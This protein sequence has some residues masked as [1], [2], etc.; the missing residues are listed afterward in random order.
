MPRRRRAGTAGSSCATGA[1]R[2]YRSAGAP[3]AQQVL[4][5]V[6]PVAWLQWLPLETIAFPGCVAA[7]RVRFALAAGA[8]LIGWDVLALGLPAATAPFD[9]ATLQQELRWRGRWL[10]RVRLDAHD[11][12]SLAAGPGLDR[13]RVV[14]TMWWAGG[15]DVP[16]A[17]A[18][19]LLE[20]ARAVMAD[21][22]SMWCAG[23]T[24]PRPGPVVVRALAQQVEP[25]HRLYVAV[26]AAWRRVAWH[27]D[28]APPRVWRL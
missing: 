1:T 2:L 14:A 27:L 15:D 24:R 25:V 16:Q 22:V 3:T 20:A 21:G 9:A 13:L 6:G 4:L 10:E 12:A 18:E 11:T 7:N 28:E 26:R 23:A 17:R 5:E 8:E 19:V